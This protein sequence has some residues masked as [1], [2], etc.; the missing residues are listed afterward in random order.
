MR[1]ESLLV[2]TVEQLLQHATGPVT[3]R[4]GASNAR[5]AESMENQP[6]LPVCVASATTMRKR[7]APTP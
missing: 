5:V 1:K 3:W 2:E 6:D 7:R 4:I